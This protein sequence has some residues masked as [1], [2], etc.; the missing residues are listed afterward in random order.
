MDL[1]HFNL[2]TQKLAQTVQFYE[3]ILGLTQGPRPVQPVNGSWLYN[4]R[5]AVLHLLESPATAVATGP[6]D[7]VAFAS[8]GL[9]ALLERLDRAGIARIARAIPG[10]PCVQVQFLDPNGVM[11]EANFTDE[12]LNEPSESLSTDGHRLF[13]R[14]RTEAK[15]EV[16]TFEGNGITTTYE[17]CGAG[18][19]LVLIHGA[20]A[21]RKSFAPVLPI[22]SQHF[23]CL[24]YDQRDSGD[25]SNPP[26]DYTAA[27]L[28]DDAAALIASLAPKAHVWG[29]S[30]GG[31]VAQELALRH[32]HVVDGL[33]LGVT[34]QRGG[35]SLANPELFLTLRKRQLTDPSARLELL[36]L[37]FSQETAERRPELIREALNAF[38]QRAPDVLSRRTRVS[39]QFSSEGR[40]AGIRARTLVLGAIQDRVIDPMSS[41]RIAQEIPGATLTFLGGVGH[42]LAFEAPDRVAYAI[43]DFLK[44]QP[45]G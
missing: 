3:Q 5:Q 9:Q 42:A 36:S 25:T 38:S 15:K 39:Q 7:H 20:E 37:F 23:T 8:K 14:L 2:R 6:L 43:T 29:N 11:V 35:A 44:A 41:W 18:P 22:L 16:R 24:T 40:L 1:D 32:P 13:A 10:T 45:H 31:M 30:Y 33:I 17:L 4:E 12:V 27:D 28:A 19:L 34:F 26:Q 21:D